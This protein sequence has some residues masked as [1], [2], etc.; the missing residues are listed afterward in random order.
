MRHHLIKVTDLAVLLRAVCWLYNV[1]NQINLQLLNRTLR[2]GRRFRLGRTLHDRL[3]T[4]GVDGAQD[5]QDTTDL[6]HCISNA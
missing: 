2:I 1:L 5:A 3:L 6:C 4:P